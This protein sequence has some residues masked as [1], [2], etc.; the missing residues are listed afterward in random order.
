[1]LYYIPVVNLSLDYTILVLDCHSSHMEG[2]VA[3]QIAQ[4]KEILLLVMLSLC[5]YPM[6]ALYMTYFTA[7]N[8][9]TFKV[10]VAA[11]KLD[12]STC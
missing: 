11:T 3:I 6:Q 8:N 2:L 4:N 9:A 1:V 10:S 7:H 12:N 5:P